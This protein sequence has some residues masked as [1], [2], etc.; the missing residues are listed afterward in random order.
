MKNAILIGI[1]VG[2]SAVSGLWT[3]TTLIKGADIVATGATKVKDKLISMKEKR[4]LV[5]KGVTE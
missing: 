4:N 3:I 1:G 2:I 5:K